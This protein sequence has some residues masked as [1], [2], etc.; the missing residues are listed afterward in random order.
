[1]NEL[2]EHELALLRALYTAAGKLNVGTG[3]SYFTK[4]EAEQVCLILD[5]LDTHYDSVNQLDRHF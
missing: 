1:M 5:R 2:E 4:A 3:G